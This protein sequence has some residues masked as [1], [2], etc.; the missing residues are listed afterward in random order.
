MPR[1]IDPKNIVVMRTDR[2]G[3]VLLSTVAV[4]AIKSRYP[5]ASVTFVTSEYSKD[6]VSGRDDIREVLTVD[7]TGG[8]GWLKEAMA[9]SAELKK[10]R[11]DASLVMNPHKALHLA[12][13]LAGI[14]VRAGYD[15]KWGFLLNRKTRDLRDKG[16]KHEVEYAM[17]LL[18]TLDV[19]SPP[20]APRL[21]VSAE[22]RSSLSRV[23]TEKGLDPDVPFVVV[24]PGSSNPAKI[25]PGERYS[26]L[27]GKLS[28][29]LGRRVAVIG[30]EE[31]K[32]L[33]AAIKNASGVEAVD[34][35]GCLDIGQ[36]AAL[37]EKA[38]LFIGND[39]GPMHMAAALGVPVIAIFGRNIPGVSPLRWGPR[40]KGNVVFH[41][42]PGC[43]P[44]YDRKCPYDYRC[45]RAI[46]VDAV[47]D[48][49]KDML[50]KASA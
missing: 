10:R 28:R 25:W 32:E 19:E 5:G 2:I 29:S 23:L 15:R 46:T 30:T 9:L 33:V 45:L 24:H 26:A 39:A 22:A 47:F 21:A 4:D 12:C 27:V 7:T 49:A 34:L 31:E 37:I 35:A 42:D 8:R 14:P 3:E 20:P 18:R 40:G 11:F 6:L 36:L 38:E 43:E 41:E 1:K 13:F 44:C 17:D 48:A 50:Q 16:Q